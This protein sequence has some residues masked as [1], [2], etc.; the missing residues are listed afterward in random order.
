M[1]CSKWLNDI[2]REVVET[3]QEFD[4]DHIYD[5]IPSGEVDDDSEVEENKKPSIQKKIKKV[6]DPTKLPLSELSKEER[7]QYFRLLV[8]ILDA[9]QKYNHILN[10]LTGPEPI[11]RRMERTYGLQDRKAATVE[12]DRLYN[13]VR[14]KIAEFNKLF[15]KHLEQSLTVEWAIL[16]ARKRNIEKIQKSREAGEILPFWEI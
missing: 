2:D 16:H 3:K 12:K 15:S 11:E 8:E 5:V 13:A 1:A 4:G 10:G 14:T 7:R 9:G 6:S